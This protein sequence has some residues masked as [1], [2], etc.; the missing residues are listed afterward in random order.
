[1]KAPLAAAISFGIFASFSLPANS[2]KAP[3]FLKQHTISVAGLKDVKPVTPRFNEVAKPPLP[4]VKRDFTK[5]ANPWK[6]GSGGGGGGKSK[7]GRSGGP[8][9]P[10][11]RPPRM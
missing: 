9:G 8:K 7:K 4:P 5:A 10:K 2:I 6:G 11:W 3:I 1:M